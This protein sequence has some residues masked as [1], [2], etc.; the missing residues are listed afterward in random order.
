MRGKGLRGSRIY[1]N[2][3]HTKLQNLVPF[4]F[5]QVIYNSQIELKNTNVEEVY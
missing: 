2:L 5:G 4:F 3:L 1:T